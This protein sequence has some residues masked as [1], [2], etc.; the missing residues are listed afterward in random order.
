MDM[1]VGGVLIV[2]LAIPMLIVGFAIL[3]QSGRPVLIRQRRIGQGGSEYLMWK[4]RTLPADT[5][6]MA[7]AELDPT[8][9]RASALGRFLRRYSVDELPQLLNVLGGEMSLVGPRPALFTQTDLVS[10]RR[11]LGALA[12][13]PGVTGLAQVGGRENL[14]LE[15]KVALDAHYVRTLS[16]GHDVSIL[17]RT[18]AAILRARGS[19]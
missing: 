4:F 19:F 10:M 16:L 2:M 12:V 8:V 1:V 7:K 6:Q 9:F 15:Q 11:P 17:F 14:T 5:P 13:K 18:I 3:A